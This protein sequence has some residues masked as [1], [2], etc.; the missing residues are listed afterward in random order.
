[1]TCRPCRPSGDVGPKWKTTAFRCMCRMSFS[2]QG[3]GP[4]L[5]DTLADLDE[6]PSII[7]HLGEAPCAY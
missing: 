2:V 6:L 1:M 4:R 3:R 5:V 7:T